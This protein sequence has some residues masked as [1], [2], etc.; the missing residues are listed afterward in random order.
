MSAFLRDIARA[1]GGDISGR[2][3]VAPGPDH[4]RKDRSL[5]VKLSAS[6][7]DG[8]IVHSHAGDDWRQCRDY[9]RGKL[10]LAAFQPY[11]RRTPPRQRTHVKATPPDNAKTAARL[12]RQAVD[13][14]GTL[15]EIYLKG[16]GLELP[17]EAAFEAIRFHADCPVGRGERFPAMVCLVRNIITNEPK[18][19]HRTALAKNGAAIKRNGKTFRLS[20]GPVAGGAIKLDPDEDVLHGLAIG[21]GVE[22]CLSGRQMGFRPV[23]SAVNT[24]GIATFPILPAIDGL[25]IFRE[26]D[27]NGA[28]A[29]AVETCCRRWYAAGR[30][31][32]VVDPDASK[33]LNDEL[34]GRQ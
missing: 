13:P 19:I 30:D 5:S 7:P 9:V 26:N 15:V 8:F 29:N 22:T 23:W 28:S 25:R 24:A 16:R 11:E 18:A 14:R 32:I 34:R 33:D 21:E 4:S 20:L 1:L 17:D 2:S 31:I 10:G 27:P 12:W 6:S 3:V